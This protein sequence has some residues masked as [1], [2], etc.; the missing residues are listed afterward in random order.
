MMRQA[1][2]REG[3]TRPGRKHARVRD[4]EAQERWRDAL[5]VERIAEESKCFTARAFNLPLA[6]KRVN[7][8][9]LTALKC[10]RAVAS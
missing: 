7:S 5:Q 10:R 3:D 8:H 2:R 6:F 4:S 9:R 1:A